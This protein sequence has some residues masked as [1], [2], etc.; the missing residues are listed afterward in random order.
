MAIP[1]FVF[2]VNSVDTDRTPHSA[3]SDLGLQSLPMS[4]FGDARH[5]WVKL[6]PLTKIEYQ[7]SYLTK[8]IRSVG[9]QI[10]INLIAVTPEVKLIIRVHV[11][12]EPQRRGTYLR[13]WAPS[14]DSDQTAHARSL[15]RIFA[16]RIFR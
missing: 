16:E 2:N 13:T 12:F 15:I 4:L 8:T 6:S 9:V 11:L 1:A 14:E 10:N 5:R 7:V 3:A